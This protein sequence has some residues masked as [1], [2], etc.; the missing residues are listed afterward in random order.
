MLLA[1]FNFF[2]ENKMG[3]LLPLALTPLPFTVR[4]TIFNVAACSWN[5]LGK[6]SQTVRTQLSKNFSLSDFQ[7]TEGSPFQRNPLDLGALDP[8]GPSLGWVSPERWV[9]I[10]NRDKSVDLK[11]QEDLGMY[12]IE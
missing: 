9:P 5:S 3:I 6:V 2:N 11:K 8:G 4:E 12:G 10:L 1:I 7:Q